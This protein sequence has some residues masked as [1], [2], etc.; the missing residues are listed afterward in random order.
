MNISQRIIQYVKY[1]IE[2]ASVNNQVEN[3]T[4]KQRSWLVLMK[5]ATM[6]ADVSSLKKLDTFGLDFND[7]TY[8]GNDAINLLLK[9]YNTDVDKYKFVLR[10]K[11]KVTKDHLMLLTKMYSKS[12]IRIQKEFSKVLKLLITKLK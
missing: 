3:L 4:K 1:D 12:D 7:V 9:I 2:N 10:N 6:D 8:N 11:A 5:F